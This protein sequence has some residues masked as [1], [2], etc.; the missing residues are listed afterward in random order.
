MHTATRI[1]NVSETVFYICFPT[2][3]SKTNKQPLER[4]CLQVNS[5]LTLYPI[6]DKEPKIIA[7]KHGG[8]ATV[9]L[10]FLYQNYAKSLSITASCRDKMSAAL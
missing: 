4:D 2:N 3:H 7:K 10:Q 5:I 8:K 6:I 1:S 9:L